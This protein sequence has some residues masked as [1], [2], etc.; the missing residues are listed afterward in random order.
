MRKFYREY[1]DAPKLQPL[2]GEIAWTKNTLILYRCADPLSC[3]YMP[4]PQLSN[5]LLDNSRSQRF[6]TREM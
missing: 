5:K 6:V 1:K 3:V 4:L 2:A